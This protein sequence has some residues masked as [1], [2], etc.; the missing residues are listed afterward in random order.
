MSTQTSRTAV[1]ISPVKRGLE[2]KICLPGSKSITN[3]ALLIAS[4]S[5]GTSVL[6]G[7]LASDDT[8]HMS[9]AL[10]R[11]GVNVEHIDATTFKVTGDRRLSAPDGPLFLGN[12]GTAMRFLTVAA[13]MT[14]GRVVLDG[15]EHM[16][17]RPI[18]PLVTSMREL[19]VE[20]KTDIGTPPVEV[21]GCANLKGGHVKIDGSL[22]SQYISAIMMTAA[23]GNSPTEIEILGGKI[24]GKGYID[25]TSSVMKSFGANVAQ[26]DENCWI[27]KPTGYTARDYDIEPDASAATYLW[28]AEVL[29]GGKI[30]L[31]VSPRDMAQ[32]DAKSFDIISMFP[33]LPEMVDGSQIQDSIPTLAVLAAFNNSTVCFTGISNLRVKECD[34]IEAVA[35]GLAAINPDLVH[36]DGDDL[37]VY[38]NPKLAG[39]HLAADIDSYADHRIA[40]SFALAGLCVS[41]IRILDPNCV[42]KTFPSYW[43]ELAKLGVEL[44]F[45]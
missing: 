7:A 43:D 22:S 9:L 1:R 29:T 4:L 16:R 41:G 14:N 42:S 8:V 17:K 45:E 23:L 28:A 38:G 18:G 30:E 10:R 13:S 6:R 44:S 31:G 20:V 25:I 37:I 36:V 40:M 2:G 32:P 11:M 35:A 21:T 27:I 5:T 24:G 12:A 34:R 26:K 15:D 39:Q 19:G 33:N 3:R